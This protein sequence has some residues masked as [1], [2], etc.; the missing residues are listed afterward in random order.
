MTSLS[1]SEVVRLLE[2]MDGDEDLFRKYIAHY[3]VRDHRECVGQCKT[4]MVVNV[5][6]N[7]DFPSS[8][9]FATPTL[10]CMPIAS[11][12]AAL[13]PTRSLCPKWFNSP[14]LSKRCRAR[15]TFV[16]KFQ[17]ISHGPRGHILCVRGTA[18]TVHRMKI[19]TSEWCCRSAVFCLLRIQ[20][21]RAC[22]TSSAFQCKPLGRLRFCQ[23]KDVIWKL[24][25]LD[26]ETYHDT[27]NLHFPIQ[28]MSRIHLEQTPS[29]R[30][31]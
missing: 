2:R 31:T 26:I 16:V 30:R 24:R 12:Q 7:F 15:D 10:R 17:Q 19:H 1:A 25:S 29:T 5:S 6:C 28:G 8:A 20:P 3:Y 4:F 11:A 21:K 9:H 18:S 14:R 13:S 27:L 23:L 22:P